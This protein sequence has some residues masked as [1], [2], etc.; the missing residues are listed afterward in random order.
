MIIILQVF[1]DEDRILFKKYEA[2]IYLDEDKEINSDSIKKTVE[3]YL[4]N[5]EKYKKRLEKI[6]ESFKEERNERK[7]ILE[8]VFG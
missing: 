6:A 5:K 1:Q 2:G 4:V 3:T 8:K 7:K